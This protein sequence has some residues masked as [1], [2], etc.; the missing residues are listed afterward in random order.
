M[1]SESLGFLFPGA[2]SLALGGIMG[3]AV[4]YAIKKIFKIAVFVLGCFFAGIV[5]LSYKGLV[6]VNWNSIT[7]QT[8]EALTNVAIQTMKV[9][10]QTAQ[11]LQHNGFTSIDMGSL[12]PVVAGAGFLPGFFYGL[13][14]G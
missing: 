11:Q 4:G 2:G 12:L 1:T 10:I 5:W 14:R 3:V 9:T 6:S 8:Q 13:T 7:N